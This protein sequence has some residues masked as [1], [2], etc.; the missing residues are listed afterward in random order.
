MSKLTSAQAMYHFISGYTAKIPGTEDGITDPTV[1]FSACFGQ[2]FLVWHPVKYAEMLA[3]RMSKHSAD[4]WLINTGWIGGAFGRGGRR[5]PLKYT[6]AIIDAIHDGSLSSSSHPYELYPVFNLHVPIGCPGVPSE[7]LHPERAWADQTVF[8]EKRQML[9][10]LFNEN[11]A[12]YEAQA[13]NETRA[14]GPVL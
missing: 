12:V 6:R 5:I 13:S 4:A 14:A 10:K 9:A 2:P 7:I 11:F 3:E 1:T 8:E